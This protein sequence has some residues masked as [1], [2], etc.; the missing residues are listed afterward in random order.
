MSNTPN[1]TLS[2]LKYFSAV[3]EAGSFKEAADKLHIAQSALSAAISNL[4]DQFSIQLFIRKH[5]RGVELTRSGEQLLVS[6]RQLLSQAL[7]LG[8]FGRD[9]GG[10]LTG[11]LVIGC[12]EFIAPFIL[13]TLLSRFR[14]RYPNVTIRVQEHDLEGIEQSLLHATSDIALLYDIN[15]SPRLE[16][17]TIASFPP[18]V[19]LPPR[20]K[21]ASKG[22]ISLSELADEPFIQ[23]DLPNSRDYSENLAKHFGVKLNVAFRTHSF[24][25]VR[26]LVGHG[27]GYSILNQRR[28]P[29]VTYDGQKLIIRELAGNPPSIDLVLARVS[30]T[31]LS[32]RAEAFD[33]FCTDYFDKRDPSKGKKAR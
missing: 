33:S 13:P 31:R 10:S 12:F 27:H 19:L 32:T 22:K 26:G 17:K 3:A 4:E 11:D 6:A 1:F 5:A 23:I 21:L 14:T 15:L 24:E 16:R 9:L 25:M 8:E 7:K 20:H 30:G 2:Q 29:D 18:Y 28:K